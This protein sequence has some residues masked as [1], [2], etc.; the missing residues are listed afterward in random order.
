[1]FYIGVD[2]GQ[3]NDYTAVTVVE[4][5]GDKYVVKALRKYNLG[6]DYPVIVESLA[7]IYGMEQLYGKSLMVVDATGVGRAVIDMIITKSVPLVATTITGGG[8][9]TWKGSRVNVPKQEL[10]STLQVCLQT[11]KV[12]F[13]R[14]L[15]GTKDLFT[16]LIHFKAKRAPSGAVSFEAMRD[17]IH[18]DMVISLALAIWYGEARSLSGNRVRIIGGN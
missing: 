14:D 4:E 15:D 10:V 3:A 11:K 7:C 6:I 17:S 9:V 5:I 16:E 12:V 2:I 1:M 8:K 13:P 18:D